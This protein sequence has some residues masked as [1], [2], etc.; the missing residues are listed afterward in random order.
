MLNNTI[1]YT[2]KKSIDDDI[3]NFKNMLYEKELLLKEITEYIQNNCNHD[4]ITDY[5]DK[6]EGFKE[7]ICIKYCKLCEKTFNN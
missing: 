7:S 1:L 2:L 3:F 6:L 5:I 4:I